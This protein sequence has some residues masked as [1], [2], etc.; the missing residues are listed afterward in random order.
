MA[1]AR[2]I[3]DRFN[4]YYAALYDADG[5]DDIPYG[6]YRGF[7]LRGETII[8]DE[9]ELI[10]QLCELRQDIFISD[11]ELAALAM[12]YEDVSALMACI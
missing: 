11:R 1:K 8:H 3:L 4:D 12:A 6:F 10:R 5:R 7:M 9:P 2:E